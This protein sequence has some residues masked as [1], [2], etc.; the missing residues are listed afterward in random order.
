MIS[1]SLKSL[2]DDTEIP[3]STVSGENMGGLINVSVRAAWVVLAE[4][5][6]KKAKVEMKVGQINV[7]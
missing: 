3:Q 4:N 2:I 5:E 7:L 6:K 1:K